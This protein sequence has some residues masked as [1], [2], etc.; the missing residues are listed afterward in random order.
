MRTN[1]K[2]NI[3]AKTLKMV[4]AQVAQA[5]VEEVHPAEQLGMAVHQ[6]VEDGISTVTDGIATGAGYVFGFVKGLVKGH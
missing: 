5:A 4:K 2:R 3:P 1:T 6:A